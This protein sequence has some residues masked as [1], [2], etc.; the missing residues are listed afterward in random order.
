MADISFGQYI[1]DLCEYLFTSYNTD[2]ENVSL[3][4]DISDINMDVTRGIPCALFMNELISNAL[5]HA[6]PENR[7]GLISISMQQQ[8]QHYQLVI[9]DN[10]IGTSNIPDEYDSPSL[11]NQ[12]VAIFTEQLHGTLETTNQ[13]GTTF[14]LTF[15]A[16]IS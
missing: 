14:S 15:P 5:E 16:A 12:L 13:N 8:N 6:F 9:S 3:H 10:G 1:R 4:L 7:K 2:P 11:G